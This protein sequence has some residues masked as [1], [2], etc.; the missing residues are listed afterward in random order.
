MIEHEHK[1]ELSKSA[2]LYLKAI[3]PFN[4]KLSVYKPSHFPTGLE[5]YNEEEK[6]FY[7][8]IRLTSSEFVG[9]KIMDLEKTSS[10]PGLFVE[11]YS[12]GSLN[13]KELDTLKDRL[14]RSYGVNDDINEF[15]RHAKDLGSIIT[16]LNGMRNSCVE[17]LY[18]ITNISI[19]LQNTNVK[20]TESMMRNLLLK[21]GDLTTFSG[22]SL[23][24]FYSP[25]SIARS[26]E[27]V[28]RGLK[29]GYRANYILDIAKY[30]L[31]NKDLESEIEKMPPE[32]AKDK[33]LE[34]K[35]IGPYTANLILF[36]YLRHP[37]FINFDV[38]NRKLLSRF[39][40]GVDNVPPQDLADECEKRWGKYKGHAALYVIENE[41]IQ[42]PKLQY[43]KDS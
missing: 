8:T 17:S 30:F 42:N 23:F 22:K 11:I 40:F 19:V 41:F 20:R 38:W 31:K 28:L 43:W 3:S 32:E 21:Y 5:S 26:S 37:G 35:G 18:E 16:N 15:Y 9:V 6:C 10:K 13:N 33:L 4:F 34:I 14:E 12:R 2:E 1:T 29:L 39:L 36:S 7:R 24:V 25:E 27:Q